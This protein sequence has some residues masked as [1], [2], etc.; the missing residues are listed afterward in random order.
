M[1]SA[2]RHGSWSSTPA[3]RRNSAGSPGRFGSGRRRPGF[4]RG[5]RR[6]GYLL[7]EVTLLLVL[8]I[9]AINVV[10]HRPVLESFLFSVAIAVGLTPQLLPAIISVNLAHGA[11]RMARE[12]VI[13]RRLASIEN[14]G[15]MDVLCSDKTG[16]L[17]EGKVRLRDVV[18][19]SGKPSEKARLYAYLNASFQSGYSNPIDDGHRR[20]GVHGGDRLR[21]SSTRSPTI[22]SASDSACWSPGAE[23]TC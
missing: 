9:F 3:R 14:L 19:A 7:L 11:R 2:A 4:E 13:V 12:R 1:S 22:S 16:T 20:R 17:T 8:A 6:F 21:A 10:L 18:D 5:I 23:R 15:G